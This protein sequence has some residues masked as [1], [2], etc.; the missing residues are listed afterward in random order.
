VRGAHHQLVFQPR[1]EQYGSF[2]VLR[3]EFE[4]SGAERI[5][6]RT[7]RIIEHVKR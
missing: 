3:C 4:H 5:A 7:E 2:L 6:T 1:V